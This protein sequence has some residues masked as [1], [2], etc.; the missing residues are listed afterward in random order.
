LGFPSI[1]GSVKGGKDFELVPPGV[2][3]AILTKIVHVGV[4][5][6]Y[7]PKYPDKDEVW[8]EFEIPDVRVKWTKNGE[9]KEGPAIMRQKFALSMHEKS[10]LRPF[11]EGWRGKPLTDEEAGEFELP[12]M[13]GKVCQL[14]VAHKPSS[15]GKKTY[16]NISGAFGIIKEQRDAIVANPARAKPSTDL[17]AF[18]VNSEPFDQAGYDQLPEWQRKLVDQRIV[19]QPKNVAATVGGKEDFDDNIPF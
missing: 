13:L 9:E 3:F 8:L 10:N 16:A 11:I 14:S 7:N 12:T 19:V 15:D 17:F 1:K 2:H 6:A 4:Q 5:A 18:S